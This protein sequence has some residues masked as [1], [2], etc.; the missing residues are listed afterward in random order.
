[1]LT[2]SLI[3]LRFLETPGEVTPGWALAHLLLVQFP[4]WLMSL[5]LYSQTCYRKGCEAQWSWPP[6]GWVTALDDTPCSYSLIS[7]ALPLIRTSAAEW[8]TNCPSTFLWTKEV[9]SGFKMLL[10][11][12]RCQILVLPLGFHWCDQM[13]ATQRA[14]WHPALFWGG[15]RNGQEKPNCISCW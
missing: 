11:P 12:H 7:W 2:K 9:T 10:F 5:S 4:T 15:R 3:L 14:H 1:M 6:C 8:E 13:A